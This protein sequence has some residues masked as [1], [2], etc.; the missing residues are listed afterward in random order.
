MEKAELEDD[1][2]E[3]AAEACI[4]GAV[5]GEDGLLVGSLPQLD[6]DD[7]IAGNAMVD[8]VFWQIYPWESLAFR[9]W[10]RRGSGMYR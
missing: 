2:A 6:L 7:V 4:V 8:F 10:H 9:R 5:E 3:V 1:S